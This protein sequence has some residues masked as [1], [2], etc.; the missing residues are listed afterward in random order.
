MTNWHL[1]WLIP[2]FFFSVGS[3]LPLIN[4]QHWVFRGFDFIR[5]QILVILILLFIVGTFIQ[6]KNPSIKVVT[7]AILFISVVYNFYILYPYFPASQNQNKIDPD[8]ISFLSI[9]VMQKN[10][11]YDQVIKSIN[12]VKPDILL[13]METD[14]RWEEAL[15][16]IE[17]EYTHSVKVAK[18]NR[19]GMH[20]YTK[21]KLIDH[22]VHYLISG[23]HPSIEVSLRDEEGNDFVLWGIHP[24]PPS[25]TEKPTS[26]QKEG[27]LM[28]L[29]KLIHITK[30]PV[31]VAGD[32]NNVSWSNIS[33]LFVKITKLKDARIGKGFNSTFPA[34]YP[35]LRFPIDLLFHS[36][37]IN[38]DKLK[39]LDPVGSD[40]LPLYSNFEIIDSTLRSKKKL[41]SDLKDTMHKKIKQGKKAADIEN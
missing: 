26:K 35:L 40:H 3:F 8:G 30:K 19:Y 25:P 34:D 31:I 28:Q 6:T 38:I 1:I 24:P 16:E 13:T 18:S 27:E 15:H 12:E 32:F 5:L 20:I 7:L 11:S 22:K 2:S 23:E 37:T 9:N 10:T 4:S 14:M 41:D 17:N 21:L 36:K 39:V 33:K 29:A